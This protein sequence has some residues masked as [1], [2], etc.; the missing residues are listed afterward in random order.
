MK[1]EAPSEGSRLSS[2]EGAAGAG[3]G[4]ESC[5]RIDVARRADR[6]EKA[7]AVEGGP[8]PLQLQRHLAEPDH[9]R[10]KPGRPAAIGAAHV[11]RQVLMPDMH[12][13]AML[14]L[15]LEQLAM[16]VDQGPRAGAFV[17][18]VDVLGHHQDFAR[19]VALE[20]GQR[21]MRGIRLHVRVQEP[22][23]ALVVEGAR[24]AGP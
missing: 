21:Q 8:D 15:D 17:Q 2:I 4:D 6:D 12:G 1:W 3:L 14:A 5:R 16:H 9:M 22:A 23:A 10:A 19:P 18:V 13:T 7:G 24:A 20:P 11:A